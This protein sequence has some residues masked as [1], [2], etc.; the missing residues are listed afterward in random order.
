M[1]SVFAHYL[2]QAR[3]S[4]ASE[5]QIDALALSAETGEMSYET[6]NALVED[7]FQC[8]ES[9]GIWYVRNPDWERVPGFFIPDFGIGE[10]I[11]VADACL[12]RYSQYALLAYQQQPDYIELRDAALEADREQVLECLR[13][14]GV[15][16][17]DDV[18]TDE[19]RL[20]VQELLFA[21]PDDP[22]VC[23]RY[24]E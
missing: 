9:A 17:D 20:A 21:T 14:H 6:V 2:A 5:A 3:T 18:T 10:P 7:T 16:I 22:V 19:L 1:D 15:L 4:N 13:E 23:S 24:F 12:W 11:E 8:F